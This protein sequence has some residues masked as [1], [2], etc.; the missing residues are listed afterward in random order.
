VGGRA[1]AAPAPARLA[2]HNKFWARAPLGPISIPMLIPIASAEPGAP[3]AWAIIELQGE[4]ERKDGG[5][6][7]EAFDIGLLEAKEDVRA[8]RRRRQLLP[9]RDAPAAAAHPPPPPTRRRS[10][11]AAAHP[12]PPAGRGPPH[13]RVPPARGPAAGAQEARRSA[14]QGRGRRRRRRLVRGARRRPRALPLQE[15]PARAHPQARRRRGRRGLTGA[16][17]AAAIAVY[18][19]FTR[20]RDCERVT[21]NFEF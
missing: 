1:A 20:A 3:P 2:P 12:P 4:V 11:A 5:S 18:Y 9:R 21:D 13:D 19:R 17:G 7:A 6:A 14:Q 10:H 8:R 16:A 15:P